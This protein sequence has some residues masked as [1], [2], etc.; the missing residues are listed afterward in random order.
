MAIK[1]PNR[2][3]VKGNKMNVLIIPIEQRDLPIRF[4]LESEDQ[5]W[6][7]LYDEAGRVAAIIIYLGEPRP[8]GS[9]SKM[10][11]ISGTIKNVTIS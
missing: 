10:V 11:Q 6:E 8:P 7:A 1:Y 9:T 4:Y 2:R 5:K 3:K